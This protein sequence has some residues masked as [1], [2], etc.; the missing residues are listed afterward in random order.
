MLPPH[1]VISLLWSPLLVQETRD[2]PRTVLLG[3]MAGCSDCRQG[4]TVPATP[5]HGRQS[6]GV[7]VR[8]SRAWIFFCPPP[9]LAL[10]TGKEQHPFSL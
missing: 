6:P 2:H 8:G 3:F 1:G 7:W 10:V 9:P 5:I 4:R